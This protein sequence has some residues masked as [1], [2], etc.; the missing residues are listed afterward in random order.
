METQ[1]SAKPLSTPGLT[2]QLPCPG[3][4]SANWESGDVQLNS[5]MKL[6]KPWFLRASTAH[7]ERAR[8]SSPRTALSCHFSEHL[9]PLAADLDPTAHAGPEDTA[10][11]PRVSAAKGTLHS[12]AYM[13]E[14]FHSVRGKGM[15][16]GELQQEVVCYWPEG[17]DWTK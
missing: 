6:R 4:G 17:S 13:E 2:G 10:G 1:G 8:V 11:F 16:L 15:G 7:G 9:C 3:T 14:A 5:S 12:W